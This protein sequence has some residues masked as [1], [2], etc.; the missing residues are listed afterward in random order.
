MMSAD[1][2]FV[3][4]DLEVDFHNVDGT[5]FIWAWLSEARDPSVIRPGA[6]VVVADEDDLAVGRVNDL[7]DHE[8]GTIVHVDILPG[9]VDDYIDAAVRVMN[10]TT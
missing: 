8:L 6:I 1:A 2:D 3:T 10:A 9:T 7:V 4:V 5:G